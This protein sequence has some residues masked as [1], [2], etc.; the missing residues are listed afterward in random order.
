MNTF[1]L[2][3]R[4]IYAFARLIDIRCNYTPILILDSEELADTQKALIWKVP[5]QGFSLYAQHGHVLTG[6][7]P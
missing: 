4:L 2:L 7:S 6:E 3:I 5:D 1:G